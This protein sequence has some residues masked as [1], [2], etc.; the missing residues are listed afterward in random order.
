MICQD[1]DR[2]EDDCVDH[3][4]AQ[5]KFLSLS[6][7]IGMMDDLT[8]LA[9]KRHQHE[10]LVSSLNKV[11]CLMQNLK[12]QSLKQKRIS[13]FFPAKLAIIA[14]KFILNNFLATT[15]IFSE[16]HDLLYIFYGLI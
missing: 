16:F 1:N 4:P 6:E 3:E 13:Y 7:A 15:K 14:K 2:E 9:G 8:Y 10:S 11:C 12:I 5:P